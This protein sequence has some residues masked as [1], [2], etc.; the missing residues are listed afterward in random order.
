MLEEC[1]EMAESRLNSASLLWDMPSVSSPPRI[2]GPFST[3]NKVRGLDVSKPCYFECKGN[4][5]SKQV[6]MLSW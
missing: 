4:E 6:F 1:P 2:S 3:L 5:G